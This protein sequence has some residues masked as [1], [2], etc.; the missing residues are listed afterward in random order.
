MHVGITSQTEK[1]ALQTK[2]R[3]L[4]EQDDSYVLYQA[5]RLGDDTIV[6]EFLQKFSNEV[7]LFMGKNQGTGVVPSTN[8]INSELVRS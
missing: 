3:L 5:A 1:S 8:S 7:L 2:V 4:F 6:R